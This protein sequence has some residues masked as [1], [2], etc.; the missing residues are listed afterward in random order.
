MLLKGKTFLFLG[1]SVTYGFASGGVSFAECMAEAAGLRCVKEAVSGTTLADV[2]DASYVAR[3][4]RVDKTLAVDLC[5]CQLSTNDAAKGVPVDKIEE[6]LRFIAA[7][8]DRVFGC[9]LVFYTSPYFESA[10]YAEMVKLLY[11][12][13]KDCGFFILDLYRDADINT[14]IES[15]RAR[16]MAD[17]IH[18]TLAGYQECWTPKFLDFCK[19]LP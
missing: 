18:P 10:A 9:P 13:Q 2:E 4:K 8:V 11:A 16:F 7:Y 19:R 5:I 17:P 15:D 12:V 1:S 6:G 14:A 3:L